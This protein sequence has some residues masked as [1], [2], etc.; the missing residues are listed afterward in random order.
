M[1]YATPI[2]QVTA[3]DHRLQYFSFA[4]HRTNPRPCPPF[5]CYTRARGHVISTYSY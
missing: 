5:Q 3:W 1:R 4:V 2:V